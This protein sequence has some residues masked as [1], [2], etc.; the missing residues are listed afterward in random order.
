MMLVKLT[1]YVLL[2]VTEIGAS[3][4]SPLTFDRNLDWIYGSA[5]FTRKIEVFLASGAFPV[6]EIKWYS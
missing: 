1:R 2:Y 5:S 4:S 3:F 6:P